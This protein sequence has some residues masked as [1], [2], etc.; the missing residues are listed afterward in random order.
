[1]ILITSAA[2]VSNEL[3]I[4]FGDIPPCLLPLGNKTLLEYQVDVLRHKNED[5]I[6][7]SLPEDFQINDIERA[8][9]DR[10]K[11]NIISVPTELS[12]AESVL[13]SMNIMHDHDIDF[14]SL[15]LL[16]GDT[17]MTELPKDSDMISVA[18]S[19]DDYN[20]EKESYARDNLVWSGY[21]SFS[22]PRTLIKC[23]TLSQK[24][25]VN[26]VRRYDQTYSLKRIHAKNW[27]DLGHLNTYFLS[28]SQITTQRAFNAMRIQN[29]IV[30]KSG[31]NSKKIL[32]ESN[33]FQKIPVALRVYIPQLIDS[34]LDE[35]TKRNF[36]S[37]EYLPYNPLNEI[38][39]HGK[40]PEFFWM[41]T[42]LLT[43]AFLSGARDAFYAN[44][45]DIN[46][47][48]INADS[49]TLYRDKTFSRL[50]EYAVKN[51]ISLDEPVCYD[52][53]KLPSLNDIAKECVDKT[54]ALPVIP[55]ILHGDLCFSNILFN[56]RQ[57][58]I[59]VLDPRGLNQQN[60]L[61][62]YGDQKYDV[63]KLCHSVIGLY[64]FI[65]AGRYQVKGDVFTSSNIEFKT[66]NR[67]LNIQKE[68]L[69]IPFLGDITVK[70]IMP[71]TVLLFLSM[72]PLHADRPDRQ[73]AMLI[74]A[75]RLYSNYL[76]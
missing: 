50:N 13:Y 5:P 20:W 15:K 46:I 52:D 36:Y 25:F 76:S 28:R 47:A 60:E 70:Q 54:L 2:Y 40:N 65:I 22:N 43:N 64:D 56:S 49:D 26:A 51:G 48:N 45:Y 31:S 72:L 27:Y 71:L 23:L 35:E 17:L 53:N 67:I 9:F 7:V 59:K 57:N 63:A 6:F 18:P 30:W 3:K 37:L 14:I 33:W 73:K 58:S 39:V 44:N 34:G 68:F 62:I 66:D 10:M 12:L 55:A 4:E 11:L 41:R 38:Y 61:T 21:F 24:N 74:N 75:L 29:G 16:H 32:A 69:N 1:M 42:F 19:S 8:L